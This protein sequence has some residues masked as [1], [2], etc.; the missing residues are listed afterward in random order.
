MAQLSMLF[1]AFLVVM[2]VSASGFRLDVTSSEEERREIARK[3]HA[4]L[5]VAIMLQPEDDFCGARQCNVS[6]TISVLN[7]QYEF[8][9]QSIMLVD[10]GIMTRDEDDNIFQDSTV[11]RVPRATGTNNKTYL[12]IKFYDL[13]DDIQDYIVVDVTDVVQK[14][15]RTRA[16]FATDTGRM[17]IAVKPK[18]E[19][20][21]LGE[22]AE[23]L[24]RKE[25]REACECTHRNC[26]CC[27]HIKI[28]KLRLDDV[29]CVNL[30]YIAEDI[31]LKF[32]MTVDNHVYYSK[33][34]SIRNPPPVCYDVPHLREYASLCVEL[35]DV[36][37][38]DPKHLEGCIGIDAH[39][40]HVKFAR[41]RIGCFDLPI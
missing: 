27:E 19:K 36:H 38:K 34:I 8:D 40:Y 10:G 13:P 39:L 20:Q 32:S 23:K 1:Y 16:K 11:I 29:V 24:F 21:L 26:A 25:N 41:K 5:D 14:H 33:E 3:Q 31:G 37:F 30:T 28:N 15:R 35:Y 22:Y 9:L 4:F 6:Y 12:G 18:T 7:A 2:M 17:A